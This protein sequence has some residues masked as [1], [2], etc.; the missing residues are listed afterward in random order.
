MSQSTSSLCRFWQSSIGKKLVVAVTGSFLVLF[1]AG[2]LV[3]NLLIFQSSE[4][5]NHYADFLHTMIHGWGI[6]M[7]RITM[8][9]ALALHILATVQLVK[10]NRAARPAR[11]QKDATMVASKP[12]QTMIWSGLT[13]LFFFIFHILHYTVRVESGLKQLADFHQNWAMAVAGFQN[14]FVT[15]FY[16]IAMALLCS[17]LSHGVGAIFQTLGL[18]T[19]KTAGI[20]NTFSKIY[21]LVIFL[22]FISIP[23]S[24]CF[25]G[26]GK[27]EMNDTI[28]KVEAAARLGLTE[29]PEAHAQH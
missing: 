2:H 13:I 17:H 26:F 9:G 19:K 1:L 6:W 8:L 7:F 5:F 12:S 28:K 14:I 11:Y 3:G 29:L 23:I 10:A 27:K 25:F 16:I 24:I 22:G 20:I 21:A 4:A 18:R 15:L